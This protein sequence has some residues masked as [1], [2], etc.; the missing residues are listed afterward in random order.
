ML[1]AFNEPTSVG[2]AQAVEELGLQRRCS[3]WG[4][5]PMWSPSTGCRTGVWTPSWCRTPT[6]WAIWGWRAPISCLLG[7]AAALEPTVDTSTQIVDRDNLFTLDSQ[8][9]LFA[10]EQHLD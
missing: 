4:L 1:L 8:K 5:T 10:F 3:W 9:A 7:R 2:A 6:P